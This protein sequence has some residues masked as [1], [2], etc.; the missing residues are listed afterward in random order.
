MSSNARLYIRSVK[1]LLIHSNL[2]V[3]AIRKIVNFFKVAPDLLGVRKITDSDIQN[4]KNFLKITTAAD[5]NII[6]SSFENKINF[7]R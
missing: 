5:D 7:F 1:N 4:T 6:S 3:I 2:I